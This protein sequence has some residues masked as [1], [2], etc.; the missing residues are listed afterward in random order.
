MLTLCI[1]G[2]TYHLWQKRNARRFQH[3]EKNMRQV[4]VY[5]LH[6][7]ESR[8]QYIAKVTRKEKI[9]ISIASYAMKAKAALL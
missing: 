5:C 9:R 4:T 2:A 3:H 7:I 1:V 6:T 8:I